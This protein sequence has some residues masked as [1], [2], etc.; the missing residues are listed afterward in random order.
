MLL[1]NELSQTTITISN[2]SAADSQYND[3]TNKMNYFYNK[4]NIFVNKSLTNHSIYNPNQLQSSQHML[5]YDQIHNANLSNP[6]FIFTNGNKFVSSANRLISSIQSSMTL[7]S[8]PQLH[9]AIPSNNHIL[10]P[11]PTSPALPPS[12][13]T[14]STNADIN[15]YSEFLNQNSTNSQ[16]TFNNVPINLN[17]SITSGLYAQSN[18]THEENYMPSINV[19]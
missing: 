11:I 3:P 19:E 5:S 17:N 13:L 18:I 6:N 8:S 4:N 15:F 10:P 7:L 12:S 2:P 1:S 9:L 14:N 16:N